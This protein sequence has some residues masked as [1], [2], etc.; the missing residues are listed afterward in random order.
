MD[1]YF[2]QLITLVDER[3]TSSR[4]RFMLLDTIDLR[5]VIDITLLYGVLS[6]Y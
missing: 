5:K 6:V 3:K 2:T 4:I 1:R